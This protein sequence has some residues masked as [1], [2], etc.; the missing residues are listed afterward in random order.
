MKLKPCI[1]LKLFLNVSDSEPEYYYKL[2]FYKKYVVTV[3]KV[4]GSWLKIIGR[5]MDAT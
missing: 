2:Y 4:S 5:A 1:I 3:G